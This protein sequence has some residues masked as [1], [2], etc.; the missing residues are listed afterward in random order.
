[1][2]ARTASGYRQYPVEA[3]ARVRLVQRALAIG[4]TLDELATVLCAKDQGRVPCQE[5]RTMA[6]EKLS[7]LEERLRALTQLRDALKATL[8]VWDEQLAQTPA[9]EHAHLL[10]GLE[11]RAT[12]DGTGPSL[13][14]KGFPHERSRLRPHG[15][16]GR[17][18]DSR[19]RQR[20]VSSSHPHESG[21]LALLTCRTL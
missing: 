7:A 15:N 21:D 11:V 3:I 17:N 4:F 14:Q 5:V 8:N 13:T 16:R 19:I 20:E 1:M 2:P 6:E 18:N 12:T 9:G 10:E